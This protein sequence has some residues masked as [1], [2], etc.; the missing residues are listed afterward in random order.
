MYCGDERDGEGVLT[1][2][3][4]R[5]DVGTWKGTKLVKLR[6]TVKASYFVPASCDHP[7]KSPESTSLG[8]PDVKERGRFGPRGPLEVSTVF[9]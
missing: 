3:G 1:Y 2:P 4:G 5:Q 6:F 8:S 9:H 7:L